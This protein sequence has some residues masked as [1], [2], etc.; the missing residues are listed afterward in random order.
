M[1]DAGRYEHGVASGEGV[2]LPVMEKNATPLYDDVQLILI[3]RRLHVRRQRPRTDK[4]QCPA[5]GDRSK[6]LATD[7]LDIVSGTIER[8]HGT[9]QSE[10]H[11]LTLHTCCVRLSVAVVV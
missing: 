9:S 11:A 5:F 8:E 4:A 7:R 2:A 10:S 6:P 3:V 1:V